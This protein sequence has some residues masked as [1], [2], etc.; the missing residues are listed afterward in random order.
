MKPHR[1]TTPLNEVLEK[2]LVLSGLSAYYDAMIRKEMAETIV[3]FA[4]LCMALIIAA[5]ALAHG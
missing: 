2:R 5:A 1:E 4:A 3:L